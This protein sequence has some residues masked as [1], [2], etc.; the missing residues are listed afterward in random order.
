MIEQARKE[1]QKPLVKYGLVIVLIIISFQYLVLPYQAWREQ[2]VAAI[3]T[4]A[5]LYVPQ[6]KLISAT[7]KLV[8]QISMLDTE[9]P[10]LEQHI[11]KL[12][13][14]PKISITNDLR[15][16]LERFDLST[17]QI[18]VNQI[19]QSDLAVSVYMLSIQFQ[20]D[21]TK[22]F[23]LIHYLETSEK[24]YIVDR[25]TLFNPRNKAINIRLELI[26]YANIN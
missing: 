10:K 4:E 18:S 26:K 3:R 14:N 13:D 20:G 7:E 15:S 11:Q 12:D 24:F 25:L 9:L 16:V 2:A 6:Q 21:L 1:L 5:S 17:A 19:Q 22:L 23:D 8:E